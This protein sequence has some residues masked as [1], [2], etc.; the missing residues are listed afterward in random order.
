[1]Q[2]PPPQ[3]LK[4]GA[5][6][7]T[8]L[9]IGTVAAASSQR[10]FPSGGGTSLTPPDPLTTAT[11]TSGTVTVSGKLDRNRVMVGGDGTVR[12]ELTLEGESRIADGA[13]VTPTDLFV[14]LD[15]SGSMSGEKMAQAKTATLELI[16][17]LGPKDRFS[18]IT[19]ESGVRMEIAL[20][21]ANSA[22]VTRWRSVV[23]SLD[24]AGGTNMSSGL[25]AAHESLLAHR[26]ANRA[27]LVILLSDGQ[28]NE[29]DASVTGLTQRASRAAQHEYV[30]S[31]VGIGAGFNEELMTAL[32][33]TGTG[34]FYY[35]DEN[36]ALAG[37]FTDEFN[38]AR[39]TVASALAVVL[40]TPEGV[41]V[42]DA[43]GYV[44]ERQNGATV[45]RPGT[46]F[47]GQKRTI[48][49]R[50]RVPTGGTGDVRLGSVRAEF[51]D[52]GQRYKAD[53]NALP[54]IARVQD[55]GEFYAG[56]NKDVWGEGVA[57]D[58]YNALRMRVSTAIQNGDR[59][60]AK[61]EIE[62][63]RQE[64]EALNQRLQLPAVSSSIA[65]TRALE[66]D[67]DDAFDAPDAS[68]KKNKMS[69]DLK[70]QGFDGRRGGAKR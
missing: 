58:E 8:V 61:Q 43:A 37:V 47:A 51:R 3:N 63:Y 48:W 68:A 62:R 31:T 38:S 60:Q 34:N 5:L 35:V 6:I 14:V 42:E 45:F 53:L 2:T 66:R 16:D 24:T 67:I 28:A 10:Y 65:S 26:A 30:L 69:K 22:N 18:L 50:Y 59:A 17:Q 20:A 64:S 33:N 15:R 21:T 19:Y 32:A 27:P 55:E 39:E 7:A 29:G 40:E 11:R 41:T 36:T 13:P 49:V 1:M 12:M 70:A 25:D 4:R 46:L 54:V 56:I 23:D 9:L 44:L 57:V 52:R